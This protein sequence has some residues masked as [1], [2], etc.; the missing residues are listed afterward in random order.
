M[1]QA[2]V[3]R[4]PLLTHLADFQRELND[5]FDACRHGARY[6]PGVAL[7][8]LRSGVEMLCR[9]QQE[10]LHPALG[11]S[12]PQ[13]WP[14]LV[15]AMES[16]ASLRG[17]AGLG[18]RAADAEQRA[19]LALLEGL[20]QLQFVGLDELLAQVD[21]GAICWSQLAQQVGALLSDWRAA[22]RHAEDLVG[23]S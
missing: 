16:V 17:L 23:L 15:Q 22:S 11:A 14:A 7:R 12:R 20:V 18:A 13:A 1:A 9:L 6:R 19:L 3:A 8:R 4:L 10:L 2:S 21:V 5:E